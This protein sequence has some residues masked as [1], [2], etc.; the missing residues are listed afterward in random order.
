[1]PPNVG[2]FIRADAG[3]FALYVLALCGRRRPPLG[4]YREQLPPGNQLPGGLVSRAR[5]ESSICSASG[6]SS[7]CDAPHRRPSPVGA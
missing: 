1:M 6:E 7:E 4:A 2:H 5:L 3:S